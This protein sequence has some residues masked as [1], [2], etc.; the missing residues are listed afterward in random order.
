MKDIKKCHTLFGIVKTTLVRRLC[1]KPTD[2][3]KS[4]VDINIFL[5]LCEVKEYLDWEISDP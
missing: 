1:R 4:T 2:D 3:V 5:D